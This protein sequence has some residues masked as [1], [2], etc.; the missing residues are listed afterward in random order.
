MASE[1]SDYLKSQFLALYCMVVADGVV[2]IKELETL[3]RIGEEQY[4]L[5]QQ[6]INSAVLN[7][8]T[9]FIV[10]ENMEA[11]IKFLYNLATIAW[12]DGKLEE[13]EKELMHKYIL[14][15]GFLEENSEKISKFIFGCVQ[16]GK[17]IEDTLTLAKS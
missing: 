14:R 7:N 12:A 15:M 16:Q 1:I 10:P 2:D 5:S 11:K 9:S 6:D 17:S 13:S 3:Y 4:G 8:G